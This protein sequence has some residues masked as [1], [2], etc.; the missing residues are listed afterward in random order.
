M[1]RYLM[2]RGAWLI[3]IS[4]LSLQIGSA[5]SPPQ[6]WF[7]LDPKQDGYYGVSSEKAYELLKNR[8]AQ[9]VVVTVIDG[10]TD[11][12]HEDLKANIWTN[13]KEIPDNGIDDDKNGYIDDIHG[14]NFIGGKN[15]D[16]QYDT[17]ELT[18]L[19]KMLDDKYGNKTEAMVADADKAE[20]QRYLAIKS[21]YQAKSMESRFNYQL[22]SSILHSIKNLLADLG[23]ENPTL[24]QVQNYKAE[25][26]TSIITQQMLISVLSEGAS[27]KD[28]MEEL[29]DGVG[30]VETDAKYHYNPNYDPRSIVGDNYN[31][32]SDRFYGNASVA[33]PEAMHGTHVAGIIGAVRNNNTGINGIADHAQLMIV[34]TVPDGD[35][36]DKDVANAIRYAADNGA[37][38]VNMSFGKAYAYNKKAVDDAAKYAASK[39]VL[40]IHAAGNEGENNDTHDRFPNP[41]FLDGGKAENWI[42]VGASSWNNEIPEFSCY[43]KKTVDL[44]A[45]GVAVYSTVPDNK[46]RNLQGTSMSAPMVTG[47]AAMI[48]SYFPQLNAV[49]VKA[50]LMKSVVKMPKKVTLPG[51]SE[52]KPKKVKLKKISVSGGVVN[53]Y[54]AVQLAIKETAK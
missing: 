18:R 6:N 4:Y 5:Q 34:R 49:Q 24:D 14:W 31:D 20:Y 13:P 19:Y 21:D 3:I 22:Y 54:K 48:R 16:V 44:W 39:D 42:E 9:P 52:S 29:K 51:S 10:G 43:G 40:L 26:D 37:K 25:D 41:R 53:A 8:T 2:L 35:E 38:V 28:V 46:Y 30:E 47:V 50:I 1:K 32:V 33:G 11:I 15:G 7:E 17:F 36:R 12:N 45:P 27:V 23:S